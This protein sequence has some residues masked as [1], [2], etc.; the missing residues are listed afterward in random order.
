MFIYTGLCAAL[1]TW[2][3]HAMHSAFEGV[4]ENDKKQSDHVE[5]SA[6]AKHPTVIASLCLEMKSDRYSEVTDRSGKGLVAVAALSMRDALS[7]VGRACGVIV[8]FFP[9]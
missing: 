8:L 4:Q 9:N 6:T 2:R 7:R 1:I 5:Y 3:L